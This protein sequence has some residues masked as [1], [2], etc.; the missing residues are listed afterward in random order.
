MEASLQRIEETLAT[1]AK[2]SDL[3]A[4]E[5]RVKTIEGQGCSTA[6]E[7]LQTARTTDRRI[8]DMES[9][10]VISPN[11]QSYL[12]RFTDMEQAIDEFERQRVATLAVATAAEKVGDARY[13]ALLW[14]VGIATA[15]NFILSV[16]I[17]VARITGTR[18]TI[19]GV[20]TSGA[21]V[22]WAKVKA[23]GI[24][25]AIVKATEGNGFT[26]STL[27]ANLRG[28]R[29]SGIIPGVYHFLVSDAY[30]SGAAQCDYFLSKVGDVSDLIVALDVEVEGNLAKQPGISAVKSFAA[31]FAER[32]PG[33][34][35]VIYSGRWYWGSASYM[36]NPNG[37]GLTPYLWDSKYITTPQRVPPATIYPNVPSNFW[38]PGYGGWATSTLLQFTAWPSVAGVT[39]A[40][41]ASA[42]RG[43]AVELRRLLVDPSLPDTALPEEPVDLAPYVVKAFD[44]N[45]RMN[46]KAGKHIAY[47]P[48][49]TPK[50]ATSGRRQRRSRL[51]HRRHS[52]WR[53]RYS[54]RL[55]LR[56]GR[57][58]GRHVHAAL[59]GGCCGACRA[60]RGLHEGRGRCDGSAERE[61]HH[62]DRRP[63]YCYGQDHEGQGRAGVKVKIVHPWVGWV[64]DH[65]VANWLAITI[66]D[67]CYARRPLRY[68]E[69]IHESTHRAQWHR[70][71]R[72]R[73]PFLYLW[74]SLVAVRSDKG[75]Y[76]GNRFEIDAYA[77]QRQADK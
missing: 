32:V 4:L 6:R 1:L 52:L 19:F 57:H 64:M 26:Q 63:R 51:L 28:M 60:C 75:W 37:A 69:L 18:M 61:D 59:G 10:R 46:F 44:P 68:A 31:R 5:L 22:D 21:A 3:T 74:A 14:V 9:G 73:F 48:D 53:G 54:R 39:G 45:A 7:A 49:G 33:H 47:K 65:F 71:G 20:D 67:T 25:F 24:D 13:R 15:V 11:A 8:D 62:A 27:A 50:A 30:V 56:R 76:Y 2:A 66:G 55:R 38:T 43:T 58:L 29:A 35:L 41:D 72:I 34:P 42:F 23:A 16:G 77:A 17:A 36:G 40:S 70:Y 12:K